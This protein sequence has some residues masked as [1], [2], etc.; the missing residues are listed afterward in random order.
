MGSQSASRFLKSGP[1][2]TFIHL[3]TEEIPLVCSML[4]KCCAKGLAT[5][6]KSQIGATTLRKHYHFDSLLLEVHTH[7]GKLAAERKLIRDTTN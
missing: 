1:V 7:T 6:L 2:S 5:H 3:E 4:L